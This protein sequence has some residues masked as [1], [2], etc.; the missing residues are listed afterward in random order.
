MPQAYIP[1]MLEHGGMMASEMAIWH[2]GKSE[3]AG[4]AKMS[5]LL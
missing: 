2:D 5:K 3:P 1:N 4:I